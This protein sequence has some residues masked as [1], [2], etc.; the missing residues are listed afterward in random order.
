M[1]IVYALTRNVYPWILPSLRSLKEHEPKARVFILC[2]DDEIP[3]LP[4][5][6]EFINV[7]DQEWFPKDGPN[8]SN[9]F[10]YI[11]LLKCVYPSILRVNKVIHLDIDTIVCDSLEPFWKTDLTGKWIGAVQEYRGT[12]RQQ[13]R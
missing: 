2:E 6:C 13:V 10:S 4:M 7:K 12:F 3:G 5:E 1:N 9:N 11:N 8:Y